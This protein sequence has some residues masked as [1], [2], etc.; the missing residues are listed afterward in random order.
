M[1]HVDPGKDQQETHPENIG[2]V[3]EQGQQEEGLVGASADTSRSMPHLTPYQDNGAGDEIQPNDSISQAGGRAKNAAGS[4]I[5]V[6]TTASVLAI[7][8]KQREVEL[9]A[10]SAALQRRNKLEERKR[11]LQRELESQEA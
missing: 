1:D 3:G 5:S 10:R 6:K 7:R 8:N 9:A 11:L 2:H 4:D